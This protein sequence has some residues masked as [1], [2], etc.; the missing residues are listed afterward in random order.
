MTFSIVAGD[1]EAA[2]WAMT[3]YFDE[4]DRRFPSGF[5]PGDALA[6]AAVEYAPP[7]GVFVVAT[8]DDGAVHGCGAVTF[9]DDDTAEI[10]R[11]WIAPAAR[12]AGLGKRMLARLEEEAR[13]A[14]RVRVLLDTNGVLT[15]AVAMYE[16]A[17]YTATERYSDNPYAQRWFV[18]RLRQ[19]AGPA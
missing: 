19:A 12:G 5:D 6:T 9:L 13:A 11:M 8:G 4:L 18:K 3:Q 10:K 17:G 14:G 1:S 16:S 2:R 15:E 7:H